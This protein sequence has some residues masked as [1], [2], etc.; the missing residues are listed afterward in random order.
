M[1]DYVILTDSSCDLTAELA[2]ELLGWKQGAATEDGG[3]TFDDDAPVHLY[4]QKSGGNR[5][6]YWRRRYPL[7]FLLLCEKVLR[8]RAKMR[9]VPFGNVNRKDGENV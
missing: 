5:R 8:Y 7:L 4:V 2:Q 9:Y 1:R 3:F 6:P